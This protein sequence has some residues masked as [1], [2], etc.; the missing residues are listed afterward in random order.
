MNCC[1]SLF[2]Y[3][4]K[5]KMDEFKLKY[6]LL[7]SNKVQKCNGCNK[8]VYQILHLMIKVE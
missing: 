8:K 1:E 4:N 3:K 5:I 2:I 7:N 6:Q